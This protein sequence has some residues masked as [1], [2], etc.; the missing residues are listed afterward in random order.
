MSVKVTTRIISPSTNYKIDGISGYNPVVLTEDEAKELQSQLNKALPNSQLNGIPYD[1]TIKELEIENK[2]WQREMEILGQKYEELRE[3]IK[4]VRTYNEE[5]LTEIG[6][7]KSEGL[8]VDKKSTYFGMKYEEME[9]IESELNNQ[10][11]FLNDRY[12]RQAMRIEKLEKLEEKL[13]N[14]LSKI[15]HISNDVFKFDQ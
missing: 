5:L 15:Y 1:I 12:G 14:D 3:K 7:L 2:G 6:K 9:K 8:S 11:S 4:N 13:K 10:I